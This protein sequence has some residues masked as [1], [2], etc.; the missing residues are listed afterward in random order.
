LSAVKILN[1]FVSFEMNFMLCFLCCVLISINVL[2][3]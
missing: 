3:L 2:L 1:V